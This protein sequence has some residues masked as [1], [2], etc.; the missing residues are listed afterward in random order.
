[1]RQVP[2]KV[3]DRLIAGLKRFQPVLQDA[4]ARD[5]NESDTVIVVTD[6]LSELFGYEKYAELTSELAIRSTYCDLATKIHGKVQSLIE[7]KAIGSDLKDN[8]TRQAT[9]YAANEGVEWV[10]LTNGV[11]WRVY[12]VL[13]SKPVDHEVVIEID[14]LALNPRNSEDIAKLYLLA[15]EGWAKSALDEFD[16]QRQALSRF[17]IAATIHLS[18]CFVSF[19]GSSREWHAT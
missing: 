11:V 6:L 1:M 9:D 19:A 13:F 12:R 15:R 3:A 10:V 4:R 17:C 18:R 5:V 14:L 8:H 7:V 16:S 2:T